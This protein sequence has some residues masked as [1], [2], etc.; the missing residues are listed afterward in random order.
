MDR[1]SSLAARYRETTMTKVLSK[2]EYIPGIHGD[3]RH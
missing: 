2:E 1:L 3:A